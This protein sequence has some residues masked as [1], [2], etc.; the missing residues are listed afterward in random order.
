MILRTMALAAGLTGAATL[1]QFPEFSQ[2]YTQRLGGAVDELTR[3]VA[4]FDRDAETV[5]LGRDEALRQLA[6]GGDFGAARAESLR[7]TVARQAR[8]SSDLA[9]IEDAGPFMHARLAAHLADPDIAAR[10]WENFRP[11]LPMTF[12]GAVFASAG[13]GAGWLLLAALVSVLRWP[14]R[15]RRHRAPIMARAG[16][17]EPGAPR[18]ANG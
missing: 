18:R 3:V 14:L 2:Q 8:L 1:S 4:E 15:R 13:F 12:E 6:T 17:I 9:A 7:A 16:R 10:A 11:G 5:G